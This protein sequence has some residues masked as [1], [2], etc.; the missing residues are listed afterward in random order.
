MKTI[1]DDARKRWTDGM[2]GLSRALP[3]VSDDFMGKNLELSAQMLSKEAST[4][5][6]LPNPRTIKGLAFALNDLIGMTGDLSS[7]VQS[8]FQAM[9]ETLRHEVSRL[10]SEFSLSEATANK[11]KALRTRLTE[12][13]GAREKQLYLPPGSPMAPLPHEPATMQADAV[14]LQREVAAAGFE[15]PA[16][17]RLAEN[18][19]T[20]E[21]RD[22]TELIDE[23][24]AILE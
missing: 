14:V 6:E 3:A 9:F 16:L 19:A 12:R 8:Q 15:S 13:R 2:T 5:F 20:F 11:L 4:A 22:V 7:E 23:I 24:N 1:S 10:Q 18:P 21:L 17:D